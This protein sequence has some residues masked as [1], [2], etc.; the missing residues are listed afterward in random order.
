M[1][2]FTLSQNSDW[3]NAENATTTK[4]LWLRQID[5]SLISQASLGFLTRT[6]PR[7]V[8]GSVR[9]PH[10]PATALQSPF[11][12]NVEKCPWIGGMKPCQLGR[13]LHLAYVLRRHG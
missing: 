10:N 12:S 3:G 11:T 6:R 9:T 1:S 13:L 5:F 8:L 7:Y 4:L 2:K